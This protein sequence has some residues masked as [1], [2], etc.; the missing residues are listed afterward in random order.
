VNRAEAEAMW[1]HG[2]AL[3]AALERQAENAQDDADRERLGDLADG[4]RG[5]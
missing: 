4:L 1:E 2:Q 5:I 3:A